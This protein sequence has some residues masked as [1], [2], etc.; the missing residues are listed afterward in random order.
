M[1][2]QEVIKEHVNCAAEL[3]KLETTS[4]FQVSQCEPLLIS[5]KIPADAQTMAVWKIVK[6]IAHK[7]TKTEEGT[8]TK[9][10]YLC[11]VPVFSLCPCLF[12]HFCS[13]CLHT[14]LPNLQHFCSIKR[15]LLAQ[16]SQ[17]TLLLGA[18]QNTKIPIEAWPKSKADKD[19]NVAPTTF[20]T[21]LIVKDGN[22]ELTCNGSF[23]VN[24]RGESTPTNL[25]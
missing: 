15:Q 23:S 22:L 17:P 9:H 6:R 3:S 1:V 21:E 7:T 14:N 11:V 2:R 20:S 4:K 25:G 13:L 19:F 5:L 24:M 18:D 12:V 8:C 10:K 16:C